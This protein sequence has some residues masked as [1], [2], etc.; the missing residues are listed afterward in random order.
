MY[1][2]SILVYLLQVFS[3]VSLPLVREKKLHTSL[4]CILNASRPTQ[5]HHNEDGTVMTP[6]QCAQ[7]V[8]RGGFEPDTDAYL[9]KEEEDNQSDVAS[10]PG[11]IKFKGGA[12]N[13]ALDRLGHVFN[14]IITN[15]RDA[16][17]KFRRKPISS[18]A[19]SPGGIGAMRV[20]LP[21][22]T[23]Y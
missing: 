19:G 16:G 22:L 3:S 21:R 2:I 17:G 7:K 11:I 10:S 12:W 8:K 15:H 9:Y 6:E 1:H 20:P 4:T 5:R 14:S 13:G 18:P 23:G